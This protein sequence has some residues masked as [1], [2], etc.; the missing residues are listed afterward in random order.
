MAGFIGA[1]IIIWGM[2]YNMLS[3]IEIHVETGLAL[4]LPVASFTNMV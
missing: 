1:H 4:W 2:S 3:S